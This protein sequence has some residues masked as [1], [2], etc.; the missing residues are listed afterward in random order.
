MFEGDPLS[1]KNRALIEKTQAE[2]FRNR[3]RWPP[4]SS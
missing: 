2:R 4:P 3:P 1:P